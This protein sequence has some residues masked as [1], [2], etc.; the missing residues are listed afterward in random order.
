MKQILSRVAV[1]VLPLFLLLSC[2]EKEDTQPEV[3][4]FTEAQKKALSVLN[5]TFSYTLSVGDWSSTTTITFLEKYNPPKMGT[6]DSGTDLPIYG[7]YKIEYYNGS[8]YERYYF[9]ST[10]ADKLY[11]FFGTDRVNSVQTKDFRIV[12][13][14]TFQIKETKEVLWDTYNRK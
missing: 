10:T 1:Y 13:D 2:A 12:D 6:L 14:N 3:Q 8:T 7:K 5:G 11:S 9:I 4:Y